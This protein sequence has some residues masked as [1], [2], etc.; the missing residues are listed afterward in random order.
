[1]VR[2]VTNATVPEVR[3]VRKALHRSTRHK[4]ARDCRVPFVTHEA[5]TERQGEEE[6]Q[7]EQ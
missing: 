5:T 1:V 6:Q 4:K 2:V 7:E 3:W